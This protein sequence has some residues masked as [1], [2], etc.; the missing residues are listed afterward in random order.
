MQKT[1]YQKLDT[2]NQALYRKHAAMIL[3][4]LSRDGKPEQPNIKLDN[5]RTR[6]NT[7]IGETLE[8]TTATPTTTTQ[9]VATKIRSDF[10]SS[11]LSK[12]K[13]KSDSG[14]MAVFA[15][16]VE[17]TTQNN[18]TMSW[19]SESKTRFTRED[20]RTFS[21]IVNV[22]SVSL[23]RDGEQI[24]E[25]ITIEDL[26]NNFTDTSDPTRLNQAI[27]RKIFRGEKEWKIL[28]Q[29]LQLLGIIDSHLKWLV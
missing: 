26:K 25:N 10:A 29:A 1:F 18:E 21:K 22:L 8:Q 9:L 28:K 13:T 16:F 24:T 12:G 17:V 23:K 2:K 7:A 4:M 20:L 6:I 3:H 15:H 11:N 5:I 27:A 19:E 14:L